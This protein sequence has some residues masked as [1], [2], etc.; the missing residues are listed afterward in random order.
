MT[1]ELTGAHA[2]VATEEAVATGSIARTKSAVSNT[3]VENFRET[4]AHSLTDGKP[5][6]PPDIADAANIGARLEP[7]STDAL[8]DDRQPGCRRSIE[9][10]KLFMLIS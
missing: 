7:C 9:H 3:N 6:L 10:Y 2:K 4:C 1:G 8:V 5:R